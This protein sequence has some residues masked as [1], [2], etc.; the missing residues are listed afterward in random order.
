MR[1]LIGRID[2]G[3]VIMA[4]FVFSLSFHFTFDYNDV[5]YT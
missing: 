3:N 2:N 1:Q 4:Q 5:N